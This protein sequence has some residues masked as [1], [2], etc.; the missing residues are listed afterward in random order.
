MRLAVGVEYDGGAYAGWQSQATVDSIQSQVERALGA[1]ADQPV[2]VT[3][4]G[5][6]DA[7]VHAVRQV[8]HF[9]TT[10]VRSER[11]WV[12][13][14]NTH[15]PSDIALLWAQ[16][17]SGDFHA[18]YSAT[19]RSYCYLILNRPVRPALARQRAC[20]VHKELDESAMHSAAQSLVGE[21]DFSSFRSSECQSRTAVRRIDRVSVDRRDEYLF[22]DVTAN[23]F[24]HH[25]VRNIAGALLRVGLGEAAPAWIEEVLRLRDRT[26]GGITAP[27][28]GLY[29]RA[30]E[31]PARFGLPTGVAVEKRLSSII[32][33]HV[34]V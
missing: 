4:A 24:L 23:A 12:L 1:V 26:R 14:A 28:Q 15:L 13:G 22:I 33:P 16:A 6:T 5:R 32:P 34:L 27:A 9:D 18:R 3:A 31:Y 7:G 8:A 21:H 19:A 29:L 2:H 11:G 17:V 20:F 10:A 25:M 30:I